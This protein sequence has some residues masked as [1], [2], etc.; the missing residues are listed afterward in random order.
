[1][2]GDIH[3]PLHAVDRYSATFPTGDVGGNLVKVTGGP[4]KVLHA[5]WDALPGESADPGVAIP[6]ADALPPASPAAAGIDDPTVWA[7]ESFQLAKTSVYA[8][9]V[10]S[11]AGPYDVYGGPYAKAAEAVAMTRVVLAG[12]RLANL[13]NASLATYPCP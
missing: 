7:D 5:Y 13:L 1:L 8:P 11:G 6:L 3:Q 2:V 4:E 9:P 12:E 10:G